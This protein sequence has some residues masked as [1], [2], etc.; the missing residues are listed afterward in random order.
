MKN[1]LNKIH[2]DVRLSTPFYGV[3]SSL[4]A[5]ALWNYSWSALTWLGD[6]SF[7]L[8]KGFIDS[9]FVKAATLESTNYSYFLII[10]IFIVIGIG[11]FEISARVKNNLKSTQDNTKVDGQSDSSKIDIPIWAPKAFLAIRMIVS[12]FLLSGLLFIAG[13]V[14]V[15]N[16][17]NDFKQ[18]VR[19]ITPYVTREQKDM[20]ISNWSQMRS[21]EDYNKVYEKLLTVAEENNLKLYKNR[22]Y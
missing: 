19:I 18:H 17:I 14:T 22:A 16:A 5:T 7:G 11:W 12:L 8:L 13:E 4:F 9:R 2:S 6:Y 15:L 10:L 20:I 21:L 3:I 1:I